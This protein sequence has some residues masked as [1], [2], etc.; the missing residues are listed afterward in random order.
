VSILPGGAEGDISPTVPY[1]DFKPPHQMRGGAA[2]SATTARKREERLERDRRAAKESKETKQQM[3]EM[4]S[5]VKNLMSL[6]Q[7]LLP[8]LTGKD[9]SGSLAATT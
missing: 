8:A 7:L 5:M 3:A 9:Q 1:E 4:M 6:V 2:G